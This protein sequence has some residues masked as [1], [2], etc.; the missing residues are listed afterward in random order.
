VDVV[1]AL[2]ASSRHGLKSGLMDGVSFAILDFVLVIVFVISAGTAI[3]DTRS[4]P[5]GADVK[6]RK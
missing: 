5:T 3:P 6:S 1:I 4:G 2:S